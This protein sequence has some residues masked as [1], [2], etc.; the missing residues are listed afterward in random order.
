MLAVAVLPPAASAHAGLVRSDPADNAILAVPPREARL[1]FSETI[2]AEFSGAQIFDINGKVIAA[3]NIH[4]EPAEKLMILT[5]PDLPPGLYTIRWRVLSEADGHFTHGLLVFGIGEGVDPGR[6]AVTVTETP[7]S[8]PEVL[9]RWLNFSALLV[10]VGSVVITFLI[11][12]PARHRPEVEEALKPARR[13]VLALAL[14]SGSLAWLVGLG[15]L[16]WQLSELLD[17]LPQAASMGGVTWQLL[18]RTRWGWLWL[19]RQGI[20][21]AVLG[22]LF[23]LYRAAGGKPGSRGVGGSFFPSLHPAP[24]PYVAV[25]LLLALLVVQALTGHAAALTPNPGLAVLVDALHLLAAGLWV[26]GLPALLVGS[27][28]LLR[29]DRAKLTVAAQAVWR[30]FSGLA[31]LSVGLLLA[32]G[33]YSAGRQVASLDALLATLYGQVLAG[34]LGLMLAAGAMGLLNS[35]ILHPRLAAPLVRRLSPAWTPL[36]LSR[37]PGLLAVEASLGLLV[38]LATGLLTSTPPARGPE[39]SIVA[40]EIPSTLNQ[41]VD[42]L[43]VTFSAK[44]NR[45]GQNVFTIRAVSARRPPPADI[46]RVIVR[47]TFLGEGLGRVAGD[48]VELEPG[49]YQLGG[50]QLSLAGAWQVQVVVRRRGLEDS[51]AQFNWLV[52]PPGPVRPVIISK[53]PLEP[54]LSVV[55]AAITGLLLLTAAGVWRRRGRLASAS[56]L[57]TEIRSSTDETDLPAAPY[58]PVSSAPVLKPLSYRLRDRDLPG[59]YDL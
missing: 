23:P 20:L 34:K 12:T 48:A 32:T 51:V 28:T 2:S 15:L 59:K 21:P 6:A 54:F 33:L 26:G 30:P 11:L 22:L 4:I 46:M 24:L 55:A 53:R 50:S 36:A 37:L 14:G 27:L 29:R 40:D 8:L 3:S 16:G 58:I 13:A 47:F 31:V 9:L 56:P 49:L 7:V 25:P 44:P 10:L 41:T 39:F 38:L 42:D 45:P 5:L 43:L 17:S 57:Q 35:M 52:A 19:A 18:T 1:W